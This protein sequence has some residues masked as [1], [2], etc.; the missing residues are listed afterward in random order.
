M[1]VRAQ[2]C[3]GTF[4]SLF[5]FNTSL[6]K[7]KITWSAMQLQYLKHKFEH[8]HMVNHSTKNTL[9]FDWQ[10]CYNRIK[11]PEVPV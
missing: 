8:F 3:Q 1:Y 11:K 7:S 6:L 4:F 2:S 5:T 9:L 10:F